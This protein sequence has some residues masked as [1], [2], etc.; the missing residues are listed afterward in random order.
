MLFESLLITFAYILGLI[1][2]Y[3]ML[4]TLVGYLL[5]GFLITLT[6]NTFSLPSL[7]AGVLSH[8]SEIGVLLL[9]F[10]IG[11]KLKFKSLMTRPILGAGVLHFFV[12]LIIFYPVLIFLF[13]VTHIQALLLS[14][15]LSFSS[16]V[17]SAKT[18]E[19]KKELKAFHGR[20][21]IGILIVQDLIALVTITLGG[22]S[23]LS[24]YA[25]LLILIPFL[26]PLFFKLLDWSGEKELLILL[27]LLLALVIGG[28]GFHKLGLSAELGALVFGFML[29]SHPQAKNLAKKLWSL[30]EIFLIGFF[31]QIGL[32]NLPSLNDWLFCG[33][34]LIMLPFKG[35]LFFR[36][37]LLFRLRARNSFLSGLTL[38]AYS[39]FGLIVTSALLPEWTPAMALTVACSF[40]L[41]APINGYSH[42]IFEKFCDS[43]YKSERKTLHPDEEPIFLGDSEILIMGF[44]RTGKAAYEMLE[45]EKK[46]IGM[47]SDPEKVKDH[48]KAGKNIFYADAEDHSFWEKLNMGQIQ[49]VILTL[50]DTHAKKSSIENLRKR[51]FQGLIVTNC[52]NEDGYEMLKNAGADTV[53]LTMIESGVN[54]AKAI[55]T[56]NQ[57]EDFLD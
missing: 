33:I 34:F 23:T 46:I 32:H 27:G 15:A 9:L 41:S 55:S 28:H 37:L 48:K 30:K 26:R 38:C 16:T 1:S 25:L 24:P 42:Q 21:A 17:L 22:S 49:A 36:L 19:E 14:T 52:Y 31:L 47:D 44:G 35:W 51:N 11:L 8:I 6:I 53:I 13:Q 43:M 50:H 39:E 57:K 2:K 18:L 45:K 54:L 10:T 12:S 40:I 56:A 4:P 5:A 7:P 20:V 29:S 3:L